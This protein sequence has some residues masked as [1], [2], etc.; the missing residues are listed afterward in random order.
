M[1]E[2]LPKQ[3]IHIEEN[4]INKCSKESYAELEKV[5]QKVLFCLEIKANIVAIEHFCMTLEK[6]I[7]TIKNINA[8]LRVNTHQYNGLISIFILKLSSTYELYK[9]YREGNIMTTIEA[10]I[11]DGYN[12]DEIKRE[13]LEYVSNDTIIKKIK[14]F[15]NDITH[16]LSKKTEALSCILSKY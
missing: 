8:I 13:F 9:N 1:N 7:S 3:K 14:R 11:F 16:D 6:N 2:N 5:K 15:R 4:F 12:V 10:M